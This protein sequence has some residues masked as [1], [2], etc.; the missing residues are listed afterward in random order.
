MFGFGGDR[1]VGE[2]V[3]DA[4]ADRRV[5]LAELVVGLGQP[6]VGHLPD[7]RA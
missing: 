4:A 6:V 7:L 5:G 2:P 1:A 3:E